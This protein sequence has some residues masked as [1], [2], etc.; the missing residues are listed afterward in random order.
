MINTAEWTPRTGH[1]VV[2]YGNEVVVLGGHGVSESTLAREV[3]VD[4]STGDEWKQK[5]VI[6]SLG[7]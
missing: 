6:E 7:M 2:V 5:A 1:G 4:R 3:L